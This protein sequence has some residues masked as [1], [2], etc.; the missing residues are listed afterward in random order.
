MLVGSTDLLG[1]YAPWE[2]GSVEW[3]GALAGLTVPIVLVGVSAVLLASSRLRA[4][5][6]IGTGLCLLDVELFWHAYPDHWYGRGDDLAL[7]VSAVYLFGLC[8]AIW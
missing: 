1:V 2:Y 6:V 4:A 3:A 8:T 7:L 5:T